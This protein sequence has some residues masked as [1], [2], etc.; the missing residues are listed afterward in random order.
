MDVPQ[1]EV[2]KMAGHEATRNLLGI[3][4]LVGLL[5][6]FIVL[7][8]V[9][10]D[11]VYKSTIRTPVKGDKVQ[12]IFVACPAILQAALYNPDGTTNFNDE[13]IG[14]ITGYFVD[15]PGDPAK[16]GSSSTWYSNGGT[17]WN[18]N[19]DLCNT[20]SAYLGGSDR[21]C[22]IEA[23]CYR[24]M[25]CDTG[26]G[27]PG[28]VEC[29]QGDSQKFCDWAGV[30]A[31][32]PA[33]TPKG[34]Y[35]CENKQCVLQM[36]KDLCKIGMPCSLSGMISDKKN[37]CGDEICEGDAESCFHALEKMSGLAETG[38]APQAGV[39]SV[40]VPCTGCHLGQWCKATK[41]DSYE[42]VCYGPALNPVALR[43]EFMAEGVVK[44]RVDSDQ[45]DYHVDVDW[46]RIR[47]V[48][49]F[50][51]PAGSRALEYRSNDY[52][53]YGFVDDFH[54][55]C[56][57]NTSN[58]KPKAMDF[59]FGTKDDGSDAGILS[60]ET[61]MGLP[62]N[63]KLGGNSPYTPDNLWPLRKRI[64]MEGMKATHPSGLVGNFGDGAN[65]DVVAKRSA[66]IRVISDFTIPDG[67]RKGLTLRAMEEFLGTGS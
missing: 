28:D 42:G 57:I 22:E 51:P 5:I 53:N 8:I 30:G 9:L 58:L 55:A 26:G 25:S 23:D 38:G 17:D 34:I 50:S 7:A 67:P 11:H 21:T 36:D 32:G 20:I 56:I 29:K 43:V 41:D 45:G 12:M 62:F 37:T 33:K 40:S 52:G 24:Y 48:Y 13:G 49:P 39:S 27:C 1:A 44:N 46:Q 64:T 14:S 65:N 59:L 61:L 47:M 16:R 63:D 31:S 6:G 3:I 4:S 15:L 66:Q 54:S 18:Y 10:N 35:T 60:L 2:A 19:N